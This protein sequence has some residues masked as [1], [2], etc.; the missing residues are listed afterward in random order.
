MLYNQGDVKVAGVVQ[1]SPRH[2]RIPL[3]AMPSSQ[4]VPLVEVGPCF[5]GEHVAGVLP[6]FA[7]DLL[8]CSLVLSMLSEYLQPVGGQRHYSSP[9]ARLHGC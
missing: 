9:L 1:A 4:D 8:R 3:K 7:D 5:S 2:V 6:T